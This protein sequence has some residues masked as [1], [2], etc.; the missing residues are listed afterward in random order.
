MSLLSVSPRARRV[1]DGLGQRGLPAIKG[2]VHLLIDH[3]PDRATLVVVCPNSRSVVRA[4]LRA[5]READAPLLLAATLNQVDR[6]GGYTGWT[7]QGLVD[8]L[9]E[10]AQHLGLEVPVLPCLDH[11]GP[12]LKDAHARDHLGL[13]ETMAAVRQSLEACLEAGYALLH[14]DTTVDRTRGAA[15]VPIPLVV[16][17]TLDLLQHAEAYRRARRLP[18]VSYEVGTEEVQG[19]LADVEAVRDFLSRLQQGLQALGLSDAWPAFVVGKVGTDL[20]TTRFDPAVARTLTRLVRPTGALVKGHY[21]DYV[22]TPEA[23]PLSGMGAANIGPEF[24]EEEFKALM[25]LVALERRLQADSRLEGALH[26]AV[27]QS[28]RWQK[29]LLPEEAGLPFAHLPEAR[30]TWMLRT[31]SRYVWTHPA[32]QE[33]RH[34]LYH[35]LRDHAD[36]DAYVLWRIQTA[37]LRYYHRFNLIGFQRR[38]EAVLG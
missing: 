27:V 21:S 15:A 32:V 24:T 4:A 17:R 10:E 38:L 9:A 18:A 26:E 16:E 1:L 6:D 36:P 33:A 19:G 31:C 7:P 2:L 25:D 28:G 13:D 30:R 12:W 34:Q 37:I 35:H 22:D 5:A 20:H 3:F 23:Y 11:G 8:F 29:W 14:L